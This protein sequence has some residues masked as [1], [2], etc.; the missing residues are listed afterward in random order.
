M[1]TPVPPFEDGEAAVRNVPNPLLEPIRDRI[2][3]D[4]QFELLPCVW[5]DQQTRQCR[6]YDFRPDAC[7]RF[8]IGSTL[9]WLSR[10]DCEIPDPPQSTK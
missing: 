10:W 3:A 9:C 2:A 5:F 1:R 6:Y 4:E 7:R 8:E